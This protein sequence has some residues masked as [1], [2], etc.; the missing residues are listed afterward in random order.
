MSGVLLVNMPFANLRWPNLG[1]S[2]LQAAL[3]RRGIPCQMAYLNFD[4]AERIGYEDYYW[5]ADHF[6]FVL[7]GERLFAK[8]Y[9]LGQLPDDAAYYR[10]I[11]LRADP[12]LTED[13]FRHYQALERYVE[14]FLDYCERT[15]DWGQ[16]KIVGFAA[17]F[18]QTMPSLCL[19]RRIKRRHP[20]VVIVFG[21]AAC[22]GEMGLEL[23]AQFPEIDYVF[24]GEADLNFPPFVEQVLR[25]GPL[26]LPQ[27]VVGRETLASLVRPTQP[28][29]ADSTQP[30]L[31]SQIQPARV[32]PT[33]PTLLG[34]T[35][36]PLVGQHQHP[37]ES[38]AFLG[39]ENATGLSASARQVVSPKEVELL[40]P[41]SVG[42]PGRQLGP[43]LD[44]LTVY[45]LDS[46]PYPDFDD[47]FQRYAASPLKG[48]FEPL[49]FFET[50]RGCWW[51]QKHHCK[52]CGLNGASLVYRR[53][54]PR[55]AVDE[56]V[57]LAR[58]YGVRKAC[59]ADNILDYRYFDTFLP[60]FRD[61]GV[62]LKYVFEM[63]CNMTRQ[64]VQQLLACGLGA[65]QL[66][67]ETFI[68]PILR[69]IN[70]GAT[71][72]QNLQTLKWLSEPGIEVKWNIL[73]GFPGEDPADYRWLAELIPS[74]YHL[75]PPMAWGRVRLDR[76]SPYF[77][78]PAGHGMTNPR[79]N[80]AFHYVYPF[81]ES[82]LRRLA[83][84]YEYDYADGRN[85][86]EYFEPV[87][88]QIQRWHSLYGTVTLR[89]WDRSDG[90]LILTDTRPGA[91][92]FQRRLT[93]WQRQVYLFCDTGRTL[94]SI[95]EHLAQRDPANVSGGTL[96]GA[97]SAGGSRR[98]I[99]HDR[100]VSERP[101]ASDRP[102]ETLPDPDTV[103][104]LLDQW[105]AERIM[106]YLDNHYLSLALRT[107]EQK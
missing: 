59:S 99:S 35:Q 16:Y 107:P 32:S 18:Q 10:Q 23:L 12:E 98:P 81:P 66:G 19:A 102:A 13:E 42:L 57:Y 20:E 17:T 6:A 15:I 1:P 75:A 29:L 82:V 8:H 22:E 104:H 63:K 43:R 86:H 55:R 83:Y 54:S 36:Q 24:L 94:R 106:A 72:V 30:E 34:P 101:D 21:G 100:Q 87:R 74:I 103:R 105:V 5:I 58:R 14:P 88:Q 77:E 37:A 41:A 31:V 97:A 50:S 84:Y 76:F 52:F 64:Q 39:G 27:G 3:H 91:T 96:I 11:L 62:D 89:Q 51:G 28:A 92:Q 25:G 46:L 79:P 48:C 90:V 2:L 95:L 9:F 73:Y 93:G 47:Y 38:G 61:A 4:F 78:D 67:I 70:K 80:P 44:P 69:M 65:A 26:Q 7:G 33:Q 68:T 60:M 71:G 85:P 45:D 40:L 53:K 56:L 49:L